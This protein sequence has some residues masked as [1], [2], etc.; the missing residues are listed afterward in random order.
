MGGGT[1]PP[2]YEKN[3]KKTYS[4]RPEA[5]KN[6]KVIKIKYE[7]KKKRIFLGVKQRNDL[8][9]ENGALKPKKMPT[10]VNTTFHVF[11]LL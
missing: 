1:P 11:V 10:E 5:N 9:K 2:I 6:F 4:F 7:S 8:S 3:Q